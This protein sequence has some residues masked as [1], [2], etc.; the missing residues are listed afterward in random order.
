[1]KK[2][3]IIVFTIV[4][5]SLVMPNCVF[6][7]SNDEVKFIDSN[8]EKGIREKLNIENGVLTENNLFSITELNLRNKN[9]SDISGIE[10]LKN[11]RKLDLSINKIE[12]IDELKSLSKLKEL[13]LYHNGFEKIRGFKFQ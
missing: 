13:S 12:K 9:I 6:A 8:L 5:L 1:M 7:S 3:K 4:L 11:L 10:H 2:S